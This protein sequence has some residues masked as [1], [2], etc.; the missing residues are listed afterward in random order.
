MIIII[1]FKLKMR[2]EIYLIRHGETFYNQQGRPAGSEVNVP[3]TPLGKQQTLKTGQ[4]LRDYRL[5]EPFDMIYSSPMI[6]TL[7]TANIIA[8]VIDYKND[9]IQDELLLEK[10]QG[11][12]INITKNGKLYRDIKKFKKQLYTKDPIANKLNEDD[13]YQKIEDKFK[14][15]KETDIELSKR[16]QLFIDKLMTLEHGKILIVSHCSFLTCL[17]RTIFKVPDIHYGDNCFISY[18]IYDNGFKLITSP[19]TE[20]LK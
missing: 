8:D 18:M 2:K 19:N 16:C 15:G 5:T 14:L 9:I 6:K 3:L 7:E 1:L 13:I 10:R 20:H 11:K 4:Y 17:L 12:M